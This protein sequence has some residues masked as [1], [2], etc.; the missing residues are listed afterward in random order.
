MAVRVRLARAGAKK[1]PFY[2]VVVADSR[3]P[4]DGRFIEHVG[5]YDPKRQPAEVRIKMD[6][7]EHWLRV[8]A[9]PTDTVAQLLRQMRRKTAAQGAEQS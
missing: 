2:R 6:R 8:G 1:N 7:V 5:I 4:R 3:S 9:K